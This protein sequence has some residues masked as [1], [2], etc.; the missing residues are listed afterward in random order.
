M[1]VGNWGGDFANKVSRIL[2]QDFAK[3]YNVTFSY[4]YGDGASRRTRLLA[5]RNLPRSTMDI[6]WLTDQDAYDVKQHDLLVDPLDLSKIPNYQNVYESLR[7]PFYVPFLIQNLAILYNPRKIPEPPTSYADLWD[8]RWKGRIGIMDLNFRLYVMVASLL[9]TGKLFDTDAAFAKLREQKDT[10]APKF[11]PFHEQLG[12]AFANEEIWMALNFTARGQMWK[13][14]GLPVEV[15]YPK[16]GMLT[17]STGVCIPKKAAQPELSYSY[18]NE[19]L[20]PKVQGDFAAVH[21]FA[22]AVKNAQIPEDRRAQIE[23]PDKELK[24]MLV[25]DAAEAGKYQAI[26]LDRWNREMK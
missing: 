4:Q 8:P 10:M 21:F 16:E 1:I 23:I 17:M 25:V 3:R 2:E 7:A 12:M 9:Q 13:A 11:Y 20:T 22:P 15:A 5:E 6:A 24:K 26:W 14:E 18:I 19:M